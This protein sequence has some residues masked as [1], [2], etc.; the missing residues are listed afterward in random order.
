MT[1]ISSLPSSY[2]QLSALQNGAA[3]SGNAGSSSTGGASSL[4]QTL[5]DALQS[6]DNSQQQNSSNDAYS[7]N[8]SS[9]AQQL[10]NGQPASSSAGNTEFAFNLTSQQQTEINAIIEKYKGQPLTQATFNEIQNDLEKVGL[11]ADQLS[12]KDQM[13]SFNPTSTLIDALNG[14]YSDISTAS[15]ITTSEST[16]ANNYMQNIISLWQSANNNATTSGSSTSSS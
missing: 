3:D 12:A 4:T 2:Y 11:G 15:Q 14:N 13:T 10:L 5:V 6:V 7:L 16:K 8:L 9:A 1:S